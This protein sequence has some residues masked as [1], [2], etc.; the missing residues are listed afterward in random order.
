MITT[1][2][3]DYGNVISKASTGDCS[4]KM[5]CITGVPASVF[6]SVYD[7]FRYDFDR[8][9]ISGAEMYK[10]LLMKD[11]HTTVAQNT[12]LMKEIALLDLESWKDIHQDVTDWGLFLKNQGYKLG[13]LSNMPYE[14]LDLYEK[15]IQ[16]FVKADYACFSCRV[17]T[18]KPEPEI[19]YNCLEGL[20]SSPEECVFF[21]DLQENIEAANKIGING[22]IWTGLE[23]A[24][25]DW[26]KL[27]TH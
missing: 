24:Q 13:I 25:K 23:Q 19:Y 7:R 2:I 8:G 11:G 26:G 17:K 15:S 12:S 1:I 10:K 3:F 9:L 21:D 4:A 20:Q 22:F 6:E 14:F 16:L 27:V 5:E 18:I